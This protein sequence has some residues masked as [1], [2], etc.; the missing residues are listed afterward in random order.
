MPV[1]KKISDF[2]SD[3]PSFMNYQRPA[4]SIDLVKDSD[5]AV[6]QEM[7]KTFALASIIYEDDLAERSKLPFI[8]SQEDI[9]SLKECEHQLQKEVSLLTIFDDFAGVAGVLSPEEL[10][11]QDTLEKHLLEQDEP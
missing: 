10:V 1:A 5:G 4:Q 11:P 9:D 3:P 8:H 2:I 7:I 6:R